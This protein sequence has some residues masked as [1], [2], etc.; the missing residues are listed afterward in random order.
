M[1]SPAAVAVS[2]HDEIGV[3]QV[4]LP[5]ETLDRVARVLERGQLAQGP[6]VAE[7]ESLAAQMAGTSHAIAVSNGTVSLQLA[8]AALR[9]RPGGEVVTSPF[10][11]A[12][13]LNA[14]LNAGLRVRFADIAED[15]LV[16][17]VDVARQINAETVAIMPVHLFGL[18]CD[19]TTL[20]ELARSQA[21]AVVEDAAQAHGA[22][23]KGRPVG[24]FGTGS[25]SLYA[26]KNITSGEGG[27]ITTDD[28]DLARRLRTLRNQGMR[29][30]Y[31]F[32]SIGTNARLTDVQAAIAIPQLNRLAELIV[33]RQE[34]ARMLTEG[35]S[36]LEGIACPKR[37][38]DPGHVFHQYTIRVTEAS[39]TD[40]DSLVEH[41]GTAG[42]RAGVY[43][44]RAAY[45]YEVYRS[46]PQVLAEPC[47]NAERAANEVVSIPVHPA[48][49]A[50]D[51]DRVIAAIHSA[52][53]S[54]R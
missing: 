23:W 12:G 49:S 7:L 8:L 25:F 47:P 22:T 46:H 53:R 6:E 28:D 36:G 31:E 5:P 1:N 20:C 35:L 3:S 32:E 51:L 14:I 18:P 38:D 4:S 34:N 54:G 48:L 11:F 44:P 27:L 29:G 42:I 24:G 43:Y 52:V 2:N 30:R 33:R 13:T 15:F 9:L 45:D 16:D 17:P 40:R 19:M 21:L 10:T 50:A 26:T 37:A 39:G 41:L